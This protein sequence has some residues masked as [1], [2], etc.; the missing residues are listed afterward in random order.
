MGQRDDEDTSI[1]PATT[2]ITADGKVVNTSDEYIAD[3]SRESS[4]P[5]MNTDKV[6][7]SDS[8]SKVVQDAQADL[9]HTTARDITFDHQIELRKQKLEEAKFKLLEKKD[10]HAMELE[11]RKQDWSEE[12]QKQEWEQAR[13]ASDEHWMKAFWRPAA[14]WIYLVICTADF[15]IFP[16][17]MIF[18]KIIGIATTYTPWTSL[19]LANGGLIHL[20][21]GAILG[22]TAYTRGMERVAVVSSST[23]ANNNLSGNNNRSI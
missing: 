11:M 23:G 21:F 1:T 10:I 5:I 2:V 3:D 8:T 14:G 7:I 13:G 22:V 20:A 4:S 9:I 15:V 12:L 16:L 6:T 17:I 19:T 18:A